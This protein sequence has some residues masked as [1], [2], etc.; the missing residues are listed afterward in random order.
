ME[1][2]GGGGTKGRNDILSAVYTY[3]YISIQ[4]V[5][6][7]SM[8]F[9]SLHAEENEM[10]NTFHLSYGSQNDHMDNAQQYF[11]QRKARAKVHMRFKRTETHLDL[12]VA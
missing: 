5:V 2:W 4:Q 7:R 11:L 3:M 1:V 12:V 10:P 9:S 8:L 6:L